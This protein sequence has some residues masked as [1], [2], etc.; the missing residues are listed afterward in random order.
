MYIVLLS[1]SFIR[2]TSARTRE[3]LLNASRL[4]DDALAVYGDARRDR[5][6][7]GIEGQQVHIEGTLWDRIGPAMSF[8]D[9]EF[10]LH[11]QMEIDFGI[12]PDEY[13]GSWRR[14]ET[15]SAIGTPCSCAVALAHCLEYDSKSGAYAI[16]ETDRESGRHVRDRV[17]CERRIQR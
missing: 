17:C 12:L 1:G 2:F 7:V 8:G 4:H 9:D 11:T 5:F 15:R 3:T 14:D 10:R 16:K 13:D 6:D